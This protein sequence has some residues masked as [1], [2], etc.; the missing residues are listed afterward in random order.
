MHGVTVI[1]PIYNGERWMNRC[2]ESIVNQTY[3]KLEIILINDGSTDNTPVF[4]QK[5]AEKDRRIRVIHKENEGLGNARNL[6][7][8]LARNEVITFV[9]ADDWWDKRFV[10]LLMQKMEQVNAELVVCDILYW[11]SKTLECEISKIRFKA[12]VANAK[13]EPAVINRVRIFAWGKLWRKSLFTDDL[14]FPTWTFED[15][16][17]IPLLAYK[18]KKIGYVN[19]GLYHYWRNQTGSL[20]AH[21]GNIPDIVK[22]LHL[23]QKRAALYPLTDKQRLEIKKIT[24]AQVRMAY[25]RWY[26]DKNYHERLKKL[27]DSMAIYY[28][29]FV[30]YSELTFARALEP[31]LNEV[32]G[33]VVYSDKQIVEEGTLKFDFLQFAIPKTEEEKWEIAEYVMEQM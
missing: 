13:T 6:G 15:I 29:C 19:Q 11:N 25:R 5:W 21:G 9:D 16:A 12:D 7:I 17:S 30:N 20:S 2:I 3:K 26:G 22:S 18:A 14:L 23:L 32:L 27:S 4:C 1:V 33:L 28:S 31:E 10:E 24:L 8:T